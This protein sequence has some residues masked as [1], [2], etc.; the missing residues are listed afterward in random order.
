MGSVSA[1]NWNQG[2]KSGIDRH[3][4]TSDHS[5]FQQK[6]MPGGITAHSHRLLPTRCC[7]KHF[8]GI[9]SFI[10]QNKPVRD[11]LWPSDRRLRHREVE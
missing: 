4:F 6:T 5:V 3:T 8:R 11:T 7:S 2:E 10:S 1:L 9:N